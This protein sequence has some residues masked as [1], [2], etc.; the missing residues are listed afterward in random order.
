MSDHVDQQLL[1][2][3][4]SLITGLTTTGTRVYVSHP[5]D[6]ALQAD[7]IPAL[8]PAIG[9]ETVENVTLD[10]DIVQRTVDINI[11]V[12]IKGIG[13]IDET[14]TEIRKEVETALG[15]SITIG[16]K[17]VLLQ[18]KGMAEPEL[19]AENDQPMIS[20]RLDFQAILFN[21]TSAPD[22]LL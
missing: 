12:R 8:L 19:N 16:S 22:A 6:R 17:H 10:G 13:A 3:I 11:G 4:V 18:Y 5:E 2:A 9:A 20:A 7:E 21:A 14:L 15:P 1:D